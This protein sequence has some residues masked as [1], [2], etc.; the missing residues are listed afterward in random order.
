MRSCRE[1]FGADLNHS[2][3]SS[4]VIFTILG[5]LSVR[6]SPH[7]AKRFIGLAIGVRTRSRASCSHLRITSCLRCATEQLARSSASWQS[8][9]R[10]GPALTHFPLNLMDRW[11]EPSRPLTSDLFRCSRLIFQQVSSILPVG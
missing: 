7:A 3:I 8:C 1:L 4:L 10:L 6:G 2:T 5:P 11:A 9:S